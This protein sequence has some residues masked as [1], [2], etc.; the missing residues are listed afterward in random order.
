[1]KKLTALIVLALI[2]SCT[3]GDPDMALPTTRERTYGSNEPARGNDL[4]AIQDAIIGAKHASIT[5]WSLPTNG[6]QSAG[7]ADILY[8]SGN[9]YIN[10]ASGKQFVFGFQIPEGTRI[11]GAKARIKGPGTN[12][13]LYSHFTLN[14]AQS[15][16]A[17]LVAHYDDLDTVDATYRTVTFTN[18]A[19]APHTLAAAESLFMELEPE[20]NNFRVSA[21]GIIV[22]RL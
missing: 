10:V 13:G 21:F 4:N 7:T 18:D 14:I 2:A 9:G 1:M 8:G 17:L 15:G 22:D 11:T 12:T 6:A 19:A 20:V 16:A 3:Q 5:L